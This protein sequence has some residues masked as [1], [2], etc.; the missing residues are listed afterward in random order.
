MTDPMI[1]SEQNKLCRLQF[2]CI[3][4]CLPR[5][6]W[7]LGIADVALWGPCV[8]HIGCVHLSGGKSARPGHVKS[9]VVHWQPS[10]PS[11]CPVVR[12]Q[13]NTTCPCAFAFGDLLAMPLLW[14]RPCS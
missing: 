12:R 2:R 5:W 9:A 14:R 6:L 3:W 13:H 11:R 8:G 4:W 10:Q 1:F 7:R